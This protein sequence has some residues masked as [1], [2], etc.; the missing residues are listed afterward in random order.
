M[1]ETNENIQ[2][3]EA[4]KE[5]ALYYQELLYSNQGNDARQFLK[6]RGISDET[7][8]NFG[9]GYSGEKWD[10]LFQHLKNKG[11]TSD[12]LTRI[13]LVYFRQMDAHD[14]FRNRIMFPTSQKHGI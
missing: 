3:M 8:R 10:G 12:T 11:Y 4:L 13:G 5:A 7:I 9:L 1:I 14:A 6:N 2:C